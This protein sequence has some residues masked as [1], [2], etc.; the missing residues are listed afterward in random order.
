MSWWA[1]VLVWSAVFAWCAHI[2]WAE[3]R[4]RKFDE[5]LQRYYDYLAN[6]PPITLPPIL[7]FKKDTTPEDAE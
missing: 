6:V 5:M 1:H 7:Q 4:R 3:Y 2:V